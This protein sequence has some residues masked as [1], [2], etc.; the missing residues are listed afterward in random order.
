MFETPKFAVSLVF[1]TTITLSSSSM[2]QSKTVEDGVFTQTQV[3]SGQKVY[4]ASCENCHTMKEYGDMLKSWQ[5]TPLIDFWYNILGNMPGDNL[6]SLMDTE[7]TDVIAYILS[8]NGFPTGDV[9]LDPNNGMD[10]IN[11]VSP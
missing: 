1:F 4:E 9:A 3:T 10:Q 8:Q 11:I 2:A 7:Y 5:D 6:G